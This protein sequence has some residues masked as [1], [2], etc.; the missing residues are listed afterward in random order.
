M[1]VLLVS[2]VR[3]V[4]VRESEEKMKTHALTR[5]PMDESAQRNIRGN[6]SAVKL[7]QPLGNETCGILLQE[8]A[9][10]ETGDSS[11]VGIAETPSVLCKVGV[12]GEVRQRQSPC[13]SG[14]ENMCGVLSEGD[15]A[16]QESEKAVAR[17][18]D[19]IERAKRRRV[20]RKA[21]GICFDCNAST[22]GGKSRCDACAFK[23]RARNFQPPTI[24]PAMSYDEIA[25]ALGI[26]QAQTRWI[27][28]GALR[29]LRRACKRFSIDPSDIV[30]RPTSM[31]ARA[32]LWSEDWS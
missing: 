14:K 22:V 20:F 1:G 7:R 32:E 5:L 10:G 15:R 24:A 8:N 11:A 29:K 26:T 16:K 28:M 19:R 3:R 17:R 23:H 18:L 13:A 25:I 27:L 4:G 6:G 2:R 31:L 9:T 12:D 30:G 21:N